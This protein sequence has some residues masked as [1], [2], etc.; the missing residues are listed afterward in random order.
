MKQKPFDEVAF[1]RALAEFVRALRAGELEGPSPDDLPELPP[2]DDE[3]TLAV[4]MHR[5]RKTHGRARR[6]SR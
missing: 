6:S 4:F 5:P 1:A 3:E 2:L